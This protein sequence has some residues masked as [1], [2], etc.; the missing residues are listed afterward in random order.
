MT[1]IIYHFWHRWC[2]EYLTNLRECQKLRSLNN[3]SPYIKVNDV[4]SIHG[5]NAPRHLWRICRI[6]ELIKSKSDNEV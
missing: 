2:N 4:A 1:N 3:N 5:H 6:T